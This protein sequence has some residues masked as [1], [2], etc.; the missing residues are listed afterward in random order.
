MSITQVAIENQP[1]TTIVFKK[2]SS[3]SILFN[4]HLVL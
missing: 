1:T 3:V 4:F 2:N